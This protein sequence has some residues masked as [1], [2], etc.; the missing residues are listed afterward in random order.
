MARIN[1]PNNTSGV[2]PE[3]LHRNS[4]TVKLSVDSTNEQITRCQFMYGGLPRN[5]T[6]PA[7]VPSKAHPHRLKE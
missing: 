4:F 7:D 1:L 5:R 2:E 6:G 3:S